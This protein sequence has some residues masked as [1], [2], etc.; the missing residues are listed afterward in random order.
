V[1]AVSLHSKLSNP[2]A[3]TPLVAITKLGYSINSEYRPLIFRLLIGFLVL[4]YLLGV[5]TNF[6]LERLGVRIS[7]NHQ[8]RVYI[9]GAIL[10]L[11]F[12]YFVGYFHSA[13]ATE[14]GRQSL[15]GQV[16]LFL[17]GFLARQA[18][19]ARRSEQRT[20]EVLLESKS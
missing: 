6:V 16:L 8:M 14:F 19:A 18:R 10:G 1:V 20:P 4:P 3:G 7:W 13:L 2:D 5:L 15:G 9:N 11:C 17:S 12:S